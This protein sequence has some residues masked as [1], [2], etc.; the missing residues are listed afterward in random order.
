MHSISGL[1]PNYFLPLAEAG[2]LLSTENKVVKH[3]VFCFFTLAIT[4]CQHT[5]L[6]NYLKVFELRVAGEIEFNKDA[7]EVQLQKKIH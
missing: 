2:I 1:G 6:I 7:V 4:R 5:I 3:E